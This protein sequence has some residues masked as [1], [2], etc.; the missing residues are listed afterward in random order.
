[1]VS[2]VCLHSVIMAF[3]GYTHRLEIPSQQAQNIKITSYERRCD[4]MTS[5]RRSY[6]VVLTFFLFFFL[7][8]VTATNLAPS[9]HISIGLNFRFPNFESKL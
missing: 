5:H 4:V 8:V 1:M 3:L 6:D 7:D 2:C 9:S